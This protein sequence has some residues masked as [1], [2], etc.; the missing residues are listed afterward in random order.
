[1]ITVFG[2][3][4]C[5][6]ATNE[7]ADKTLISDFVCLTLP[8]GVTTTVAAWGVFW[9]FWLLYK[10][11]VLAAHV[12]SQEIIRVIIWVNANFYPISVLITVVASLAIFYFR[13]IAHL[14]KANRLRKMAHN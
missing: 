10:P 13:M 2:V 3:E 1:M 5:F 7:D 9:A 14:K 8:I 12:E 6:A 4:R 11:V